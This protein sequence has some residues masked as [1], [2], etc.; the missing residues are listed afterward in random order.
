[1]N[2]LWFGELLTLLGIGLVVLLV[3][4]ALSP[5]ETLGWWAGWFGDE[6]YGYSLPQEEVT[7]PIRPE[8]EYFVVFLSGISRVGGETYSRRE[9]NFLRRL[10]QVMPRAVVIDD[11]FPYSVN[12]LPLT[13]QPFFAW[14]WRWAL[15]RK[16]SKRRLE[17]LA[18][19]LINIRNIWQVAISADRRYGPIYNQSVAQ[20]MATALARHGYH[21][22][23]RTP[24][25]LIGYSGAGQIAVGATPY[26]KELIQAPV[27]VVSLGGIFS[28]DPGLLAADHFFHLYGTRDRIHKIGAI[29]FPGRWPFIPWSAWNRARREGKV[30][31]LCIGDMTHAGAL[32]YLSS[33]A[34]LPDGTPYL[35]KTAQTIAHL[36]YRRYLPQAQDRAR[37]DQQ[38]GQGSAE[39]QGNGR[40]ELK[41]S[42]APD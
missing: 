35:E 26:L 30:T 10:S 5:L 27:F 3:W 2:E 22:A 11:I 17:Q 21:P 18:G 37:A 19:Y 39:S 20:V 15:R 28:S 38:P 31:L 9:R 14:L 1:M 42:P 32:G 24:V 12:N 8:P 4:A 7:P 41:F 34:R 40:D 6:V 36:P 25:I 33:S 29:V 16:L 23:R 13:G